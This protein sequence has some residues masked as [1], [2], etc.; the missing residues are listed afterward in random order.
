VPPP[1]SPPPG[2]IASFDT[3]KEFQFAVLGGKWAEGKTINP[4]AGLLV[5]QAHRDTV[6]VYGVLSGLPPGAVIK[7]TIFSEGCPSDLAA[8]AW[9]S[10]AP[11]NAT[12]SGALTIEL[13]L[14]Q[15]YTRPLD[16]TLS[17]ESAHNL[18]S[19]GYVGVYIGATLDDNKG[20]QLCGR[21]KREPHTQ[22]VILGRMPTC[23]REPQ[24][25]GIGQVWQVRV[26]QCPLGRLEG[27]V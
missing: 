17:D 26:M 9:M 14:T 4:E 6:R 12:S 16:Q 13:S 10:L 24:T 21:L 25:A 3:S 1:P 27:L 23:A 11:A 8:D 5:A 19:S 15:D 18:A 22:I 2:L 20:Q 7:T